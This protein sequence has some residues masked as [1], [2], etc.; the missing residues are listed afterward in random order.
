MP[1][2]PGLM[3]NTI[4]NWHSVFRFLGDF[5]WQGDFVHVYT[6]GSCHHQQHP[7][8]RRSG[9]GVY[10][11]DSHPLNTS[12]HQAGQAHTSP[13]AELLAIVIAIEQSRWPIHIFSDNLGYVTAVQ[14]LL[15]GEFTPT[16]KDDRYLWRRIQRRLL[17]T[18]NTH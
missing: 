17:P 18:Q 15:A 2:P 12:V 10:W 5:A 1:N 9:A 13:R 7:W 8:L 4:Q 14:R 3:A 6:D 11:G 16:M